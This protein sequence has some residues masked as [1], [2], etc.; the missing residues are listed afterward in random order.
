MSSDS[1]SDTTCLA[2]GV[3]TSHSV[4]FHTMDELDWGLGAQ[5]QPKQACLL[6]TSW[7]G[8]APF[9]PGCGS[10]SQAPWRASL[11][12]ACP[13]TSPV[14]WRAEQTR[15]GIEMHLFSAAGTRSLSPKHAP[16]SCKSLT[17]DQMGSSW[18]ERPTFLMIIY[19]ML[20]ITKCS[21]RRFRARFPLPRMKFRFHAVGRCW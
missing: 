4:D 8:A 15:A 20:K 17:T 16:S 9:S 3:L 19:K 14:L 18:R 10:P 12:P 1:G 5:T 2:L 6:R 11:H 21:L 13:D 7:S